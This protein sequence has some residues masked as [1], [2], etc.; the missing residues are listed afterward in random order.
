MCSSGSHTKLVWPFQI[1][2]FFLERCLNWD[3]FHVIFFS[4]CGFVQTAAT[5]KITGRNRFRGCVLDFYH[6]NVV[7]IISNVFC[8]LPD[9][10]S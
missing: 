8:I 3:L 1:F 2:T 6:V 5:S 4:F 9:V 10:A 7:V